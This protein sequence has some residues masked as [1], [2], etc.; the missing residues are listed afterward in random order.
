MLRINSQY[1]SYK[2]SLLNGP[3]YSPFELFWIRTEDI[4]RFTGVDYNNSYIKNPE[5]RTDFQT[6]PETH[7]NYPQPQG[8]FDVKDNIGKVLGGRW[9]KETTK[10]ENYFIYKG[11]NEYFVD[12]VDWESTQYF[13]TAAARI[14]N[15]Y[16]QRG[17]ESIKELRAEEEHIN[18]IYENMDQFGYIPQR[19]ISSN[20]THEIGVNIGRNGE[21]LF[22]AYGKHR[23]SIAKILNID[24]VAAL[25]IV[26][27]KKWQKVRNELSTSDSFSDLSEVAKSNLSHPDVDNKSLFY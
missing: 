5:Q 24:Y 11:L 1:R 21:F 23:L 2:N 25:V 3:G 9:D 17:C 10:F 27:H 19:G 6:I 8:A 26:R 14:Q 13:K 18:K 22:N 20:I 12:G 4:N 7:S 16:T 15:G